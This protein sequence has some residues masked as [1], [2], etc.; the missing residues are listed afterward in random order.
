MSPALTI[1]LITISGGSPDEGGVVDDPYAPAIARATR[2]ALGAN[3]QIISKR[4]DTL[5]SDAEV[6]ALGADAH[7]D[8]VVEIT[9]SLPD[10][11]R[12]TIRME[13]ASTGQ[14]LDREVG[15]RTNDDPVERSRTV[16]FTIASMLPEGSARLEAPPPKPEEAPP[17]PAP[18]EGLARDSVDAHP[19]AEPPEE[20]LHFDNSISA[21]AL[22]A[23][24]VGDG[25]GGLG[26]AL[27]YRRG[28]ADAFALRFG[29]AAR[30]GQGA[31]SGLATRFFSG[32]VGF[33]WDTWSSQNGRGRL[34]LRVDALFALAQVDHLS[35]QGTSASR[36]KFLPGADLLVEGSYF[37]TR[38]AAVVLGAGGEALFGET[39][40]I[41]EGQTVAAFEPVHPV[42]ELGLRAGF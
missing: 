40:V 12:T 21:A 3:T 6:V 35:T 16:G 7:A 4:L 38:G 37:F 32:G 15:F 9:W 28:L 5:P 42:V 2:E 20:R 24:G 14:W 22:M 23:F 27:D 26:A 36:Y 1:L 19:A 30:V 39:D 8:A 25:G 11:L 13:R 29:L 34:G 17:T 33:V 41:V 31:P 18:E 10:H